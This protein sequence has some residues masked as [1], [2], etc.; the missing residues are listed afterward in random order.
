MEQETSKKRSKKGIVAAVLACCLVV[1]GVAGVLAWLTATDDATNTFT[2]GNFSTPE[3]EPDPDNPKI[4]DQDGVTTPDGYL[5]ETEWVDGSKLLP[6]EDNAVA[7][8]PNVGIGPDSDSAYVFVYVENKTQGTGEV[9]TNA[10][11]FSLE[12]GWGPVAGAVDMSTAESGKYTG[13]LFVYG[14]ESAPGVLTA[15][16]YTG[17][18]F[19]SVYA[20]TNADLTDNPQMIVHAYIYAQ[21]AGATEGDDGSATAAVKAA[22]QW[23]T[24]EGWATLVTP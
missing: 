6:G 9:A 21:K 19:S 7:K 3:K 11:V 4:P 24:D 15:N 10:P 20:P 8:N 1:G 22:K 18:V 13:G 14:T 16:A 17:E 12:N 5:T 2:V 23:V